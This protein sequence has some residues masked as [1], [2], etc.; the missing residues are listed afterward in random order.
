MAL[1]AGKLG[2]QEETPQSWGLELEG[3]AMRSCQCP[4]RMGGVSSVQVQKSLALL[5][6]TYKK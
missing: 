2:R 4:W 5:P 3:G 6:V 1:H